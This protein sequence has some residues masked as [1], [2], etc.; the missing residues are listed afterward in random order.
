MRKSRVFGGL[1]CEIR[2]TKLPDPSEPLEFRR[3]D[4]R[5]D[6]LAFSGVGVNTNDVMYR[7]AVDP[8]SHWVTIS[9]SGLFFVLTKPFQHR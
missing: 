7:I 9:R 5:N 3:V 1:I 2:Q 4:E 6:Q 8:F